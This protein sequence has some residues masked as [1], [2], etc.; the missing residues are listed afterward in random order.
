MPECNNNLNDLEVLLLKY[1][2]LLH[3]HN[4]NNETC[5][6]GPVKIKVKSYILTIIC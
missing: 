6:K 3:T 2:G 1:P 5:L 4:K